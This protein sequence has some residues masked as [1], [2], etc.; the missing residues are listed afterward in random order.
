MSWGVLT[1][2]RQDFDSSFVDYLV[3]TTGNTIVSASGNRDCVNI[4]GLDPLFVFSP[5]L[6]WNTISVGAYRDN[7]TGLRIDDSFADFTSYKNPIDLNSGRTYEKPDVTGL[8]CVETT[9][10]GNGVDNSACGISLAAP[11]VSALASLVIGKNPTGLRHNREAVKAIIMAGATHNIVDAVNYK[12][13]PNISSLTPDCRDGAGAIDAY[14]TI[15]NIVVPGNWRFLGPITPSSFN[16]A[17][18]IEYT[19]SLNKGKNVRVVIAWDSMAVCSD[20]G[21]GSQS[22]ASDVL[23]A[24]LRSNCFGSK[25]FCDSSR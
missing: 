25:R 18:N 22:C 5:S 9:Q 14:Q 19:T 2:G 11:D 10:I 24:D 17:G 12:V 3:R 20:L 21:T 1:N 6:G 7:N 4:P 23:N 16:A 8:G 13:C 15:Q